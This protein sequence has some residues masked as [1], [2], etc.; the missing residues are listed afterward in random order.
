MDLGNKTSG[1][2]S[3]ALREYEGFRIIIRDDVIMK[4]GPHGAI[5]RKYSTRFFRAI[6][7]IL[8]Q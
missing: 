1:R 6:V 4:A 5:C 7:L 8:K 3:C 2:V